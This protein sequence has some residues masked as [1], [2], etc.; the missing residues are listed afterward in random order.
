MDRMPKGKRPGSS[1][2][3]QIRELHN[4]IIDLKKLDKENKL[5]APES[6]EKSQRAG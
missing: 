1:I 6:L 4:T 5:Y 2:R 3:E